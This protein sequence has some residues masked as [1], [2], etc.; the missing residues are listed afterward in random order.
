MKQAAKEEYYLMYQSL[1]DELL[2]KEA[3]ILKDHLHE[4]GLSDE[5]KLEKEAIDRLLKER[6]IDAESFAMKAS[7]EAQARKHNKTP[8]KPPT[9]SA[10]S[11]WKKTILGLIL[12]LLG[13][14]LLQNGLEPVYP[15][16]MILGGVILLGIGI[17]EW[18]E[19]RKK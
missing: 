3:L 7:F 8:R 13:I 4:K 19:S 6:R 1:S 11:I 10:P 12:S 15:Y 18:Y 5:K 17:W 2:V 9:T 16:L 14:S